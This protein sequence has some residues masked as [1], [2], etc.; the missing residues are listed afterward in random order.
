MTIIDLQELF[1]KADRYLDGTEVYDPQKAKE[2]F[3]K[4]L[5]EARKQ[6]A[7]GGKQYV[8]A[9]LALG[10]I[11]EREHNVPLA[12]KYLLKVFEKKGEYPEFG[13]DAA[14]YLFYLHRAE[15]NLQ[16]MLKW[17]HVIHQFK[18]FPR[19]A[20]EVTYSLGGWYHENGQPEKAIEWWLK[21]ICFGKKSAWSTA[22]SAD[23]LAHH[24][25][26]HGDYKS[27]EKWWL[28]VVDY[29]K[30]ARCTAADAASELSKLYRKQGKILEAEK[31]LERAKNWD[32][33]IREVVGSGGIW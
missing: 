21:A 11:Y 30:G 28:F 14:F 18:E 5:Q 8:H 16:E 13:A 2:L 17:G 25:S 12:Q 1:V 19:L 15:N 4:F 24:Y 26:A 10:V 31:Y 29:R 9:L 3:S 27:A 20:G 32:H 23:A 6:G 22:W 33:A 7:N